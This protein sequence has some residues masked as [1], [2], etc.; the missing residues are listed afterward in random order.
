[1]SDAAQQAATVS[2]LVG[3]RIDETWMLAVGESLTF[4][5]AADVDIRLDSPWI[6]R[7]AGSILAGPHFV[8]V[9]RMPSAAGPEVGKI[10]LNLFDADG[11][12]LIPA[13]GTVAVDT[14][15]AELN[16]SMT[17]P[18]DLGPHETLELD[19][20]FGEPVIRIVV[21]RPLRRL[22]EPVNVRSPHLEPTWAPLTE[23]R[24]HRHFPVLV[25]LCEPLFDVSPSFGGLPSNERIAQRL[26]TAYSPLAA[27]TVR[28]RLHEWRRRLGIENGV[29]SGVAHY[30]LA[31]VAKETG[32]VT[33]RDVDALRS[34]YPPRDEP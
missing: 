21:G 8:A 4:G 7:Q 13:G 3:R 28:N 1:M 25:A 24:A 20:L 32:L 29:A 12:T 33:E 16:A 34:R 19:V 5:R 22:R 18:S 15:T 27:G 23:L 2:R 31:V 17:D 10:W 6:S 11:P 26:S 30:H 9:T 14:N